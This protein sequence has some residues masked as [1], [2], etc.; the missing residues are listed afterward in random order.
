[1]H[2]GRQAEVTT[3]VG[4]ARET[5]RIVDGGIKGERAQG[6][7]T[8]YFHKAATDLIFMGYSLQLPVERSL[9]GDQAAAVIR[10]VAQ[11]VDQCVRRPAKDI[12]DLGFDRR[13]K[14]IALSLASKPSP[15]QLDL[16]GKHAGGG[17]TLADQ[18]PAN[19]K[20]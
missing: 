12:P 13:P 7:D 5:V 1:M 6:P 16:A 3:N 10:E 18:V 15:V 2:P 4:G 9:I 11:L 19:G 8:R 14:H 17:H 20:E